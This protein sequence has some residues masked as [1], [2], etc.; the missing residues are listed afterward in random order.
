MKFF[1]LIIFLYSSLIVSCSCNRGGAN[2]SE[3]DK[4]SASTGQQRPHQ[5]KAGFS[6]ASPQNNETFP[7]GTSITLS[8]DIKDT[9]ETIDSLR[10]FIN[11]RLL[12]KALPGEKVVWNTTGQVTGTHRIEATAHYSSR[13]RHIVSSKVIL[14][15]GKAPK[16]Y[17]CKV[18]RTYPHDKKAYTQGLLFDDG[19]L[20][21][22]TG[23]RG[24]S[25]LRKINLNT[26]EPLQ[27]LSLPSE[28][29][30]EGLALADG[31]LIQITW[32]EQVAFI[33]DKN[34]FRLLK[35]INYPMKEGWGLTYD[36]VNLIMSDGSATLYFLD[37]EYLTEIRRMEVCNHTDPVRY[38][39]EL[40]YINGE[41]WANV[42]Q[43]EDILRIDPKTG[44][45]LGQINMKNPLNANEMQGTDVFNGIA[46]DETAG[47]IYVTGKYWPKLFEIEVI[48]KSK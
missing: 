14:L 30:G 12:K 28:M 39:N 11:G 32:Q 43:T 42:Y 5:R 15:A 34:D 33:Y 26:G 25:S 19:F 36:G 8:V 13:Q 3:P 29:F 7:L 23:I 18:I 21:E 16:Q 22:S 41:I 6:I 47:K 4:T 2:S 40:E 1:F 44:E 31:K 24:E 37:K 35:R 46:Y 38:L 20:Y 10:W 27:V 45:V 48:E 17:T 9:A